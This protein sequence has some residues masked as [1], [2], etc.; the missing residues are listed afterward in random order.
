MQTKHRNRTVRVHFRATEVKH[1]HHVQIGHSAKR[2]APVQP[3]WV[4]RIRHANRHILVKG[5]DSLAYVAFIRHINVV[6]VSGGGRVWAWTREMNQ[7]K[8]GMKRSWRI[9]L[10]RRYWCNL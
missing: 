5:L 8:S 10:A 7:Q 1:V 3:L 6:V 9:V 4:Q 2:K